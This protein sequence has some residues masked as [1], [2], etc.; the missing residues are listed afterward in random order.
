M[1]ARELTLATYNIHRCVGVDRRLNM[2]RI[3]DVLKEMNADVV[4]IQ[5]ID[6]HSIY[7]E[8]HQLNF[9]ARETH[10]HVVAGPTMFRSDREYGNALLT[11]YPIKV[12]RRMDLT[13]GESEPRSAIDVDLDVDGLHCRVITTHLGLKFRERRF[14][15]RKLFQDVLFNSPL[16]IIGDMN[17]W[18]PYLGATKIFRSQFGYT[19]RILSY[20]SFFP[21]F[22]LDQI[23]VCPG[24]LLVKT[25][26]HKTPLS[27]VASDHLPVKAKI[28]IDPQLF[29]HSR[30]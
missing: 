17:E 16:I 14:Q 9:I 4:G 3:V 7:E 23:Y 13:I 20:P 21:I 30:T 5:E 19:T 10:Y 8:G 27:K 24:S 26:V 6:S 12:L 11:R 2:S 22:G 25:E 1:N 28:Q 15:L 29:G 18:I